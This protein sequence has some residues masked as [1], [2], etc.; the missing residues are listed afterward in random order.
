MALAKLLTWDACP[1][2]LPEILTITHVRYF[3]C[4]K[5]LLQF[6][7]WLVVTASVWEPAEH[8][9]YFCLSSVSVPLYMWWLSQPKIMAEHE[10]P[11]MLRIVELHAGWA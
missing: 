7:S 10:L 11:S 5:A 2:G 1:F 3:G 6:P 8:M 4:D 9:E